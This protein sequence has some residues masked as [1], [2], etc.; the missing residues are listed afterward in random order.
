MR[1]ISGEHK[2]RRITAPKGLPVRPT[3]DRTKEGLFN[4]LTNQYDLDE[5]SVLDLFSGIGSISFEFGSRGT[6]N[7]IAVEQFHKCV[8]FIEEQS[9]DLNLPIRVMKMDVFAFLEKSKQTFDIIFADPPYDLPQASFNKIVELVFDNNLLSENG[10][11]IIEHDN[12]TIYKDHPRL[13]QERKYGG[14]ILSF[15]E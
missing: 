15:F 9:R 7:I 12:N 1:I 11:L 6:E 13:I 14:S 5:I 4:I 2:G 8:K 10:Q 3:T